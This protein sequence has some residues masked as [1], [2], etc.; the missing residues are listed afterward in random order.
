MSQ[1]T[2]LPEHGEGAGLVLRGAGRGQEL[3][4]RGHDAEAVDDFL[5]E[6]RRSDES[7][8]KFFE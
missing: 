3:Q 5:V 7:R 4:E 2:L 8:R 6:F 1:V